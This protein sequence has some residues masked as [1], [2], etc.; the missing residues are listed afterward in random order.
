MPPSR[1]FRMLLVSFGLMAGIARGQDIPTANPATAPAPSL[2]SL[3]A[4]TVIP[5]LE[6]PEA[7]AADAAPAITGGL[8]DQVPQA[9]AMEAPVR[10]SFF[11][12]A[13]ESIFGE[14]D[15]ANWRPLL[16]SE[17]FTFGWDQPFAF[18]PLSTSGAPRQG[19][20]NA[21]DGVM[22]RLW[23]NEF[24][25]RQNVG[26]NG[27]SYSSTWTI[28]VPLNQRLDVRLDVPYLNSA[29][30]GAENRYLTQFGDMIL[31]ARIRLHETR[32]TT[33]LAIIGSSM[34]TGQQPVG[35]GSTV[36][37]LGI[38][39]WQSLPDRWVV[40]GGV[41]FGVPF[42]D[43]PDGNRT[44]GNVNVAVGKYL[45]DA[46]T[47]LI[48]DLVVYNSM[49]FFTTLEGPGPANAFFSMTPGYRAQIVDNWYHLAGVEIPMVG[50]PNNYAF[51][52]T[53]WLLKVY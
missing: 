44:I 29:R 5:D 11:D 45:T 46:G 18:T 42:N 49:N 20:I 15:S 50:G 25:Y 9:V 34:P 38:Q 16:F 32:D 21:Y 4:D 53:F 23:F 30:G 24:S 17:L 19:W 2:P 48:G 26:G 1:G 35:G 37:Q 7:T 41:N 47:P 10:A 6:L 40:R 27:E 28:F 43:V 33:V 36:G 14:A 22:Y 39:F 31:R 51:G 52:L 12:V 8:F 13:I 3:P